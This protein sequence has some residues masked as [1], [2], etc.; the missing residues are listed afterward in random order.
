MSHDRLNFTESEQLAALLDRFQRNHLGPASKRGTLAVRDTQ[1]L[2]T[3]MIGYTWPNGDREPGEKVTVTLTLPAGY[4]SE[5][6]LI[7]FEESLSEAAAEL[8]GESLAN[9]FDDDAYDASVSALD[10][11]RWE[12]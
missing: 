10:T 6:G 1:E 9:A 11:K 5:V 7:T 4:M 8:I 3:A 12:G 2:V